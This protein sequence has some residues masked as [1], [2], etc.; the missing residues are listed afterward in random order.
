MKKLNTV[1]EAVYIPKPEEVKTEQQQVVPVEEVKLNII[2][3]LVN[4]LK[5]TEDVE[6]IKVLI[7][8]TTFK[9]LFGEDSKPRIGDILTINGLTK[10][11][12]VK[13][14]D[15]FKISKKGSAYKLKLKALKE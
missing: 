5:L 2:N 1:K 11:F 15:K 13:K 6:K 8:K 12:E 14:K 4:E 9:D 3:V 10:Q 7:E